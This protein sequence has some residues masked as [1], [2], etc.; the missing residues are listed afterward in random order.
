M[1]HKLSKEEKEILTSFENE[2][3][4]SVKDIEFRKSELKQYA[5]ATLKKDKRVNIRI[6]QRDLKELQRKAVQ[7]GLPYQTLI[8]SILHKYVNGNLTEKKAA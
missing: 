5:H 7:E 3:W 4:K 6:S 8:S 2:E 1:K